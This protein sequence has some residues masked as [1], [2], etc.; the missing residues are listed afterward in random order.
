VRAE[1]AR[2]EANACEPLTDE[3]RILLGGQTARRISTI[4]QELARLPATESQV[5]VEGLTRLVH[6]VPT[7]NALAL[8]VN[9]NNPNAEPDTRSLR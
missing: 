1:L 6:T 3:P 4:E 2:V 8:L 7:A 5:L 9:P